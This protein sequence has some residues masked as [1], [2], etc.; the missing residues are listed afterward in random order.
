MSTDWTSK[1]SRQVDEKGIK[2]HQRADYEDRAAPLTKW[3]TRPI[4][5]MA[6]LARDDAMNKQYHFVQCNTQ[7]EY[8]ELIAL[9]WRAPQDY[10][11]KHDRF[12]PTIMR[13]WCDGIPKVGAK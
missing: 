12:A 2:T 3:R 13:I 11:L 1:E 10:R 5:P 6:Q 8:D 9:G 4:H 7:E